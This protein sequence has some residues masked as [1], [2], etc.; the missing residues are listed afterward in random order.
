MA[1]RNFEVV[2]R[3]EFCKGCGL[4]VAFCKQGKLFIVKKPNKQGI[5]QA[6]V[7]PDVECSGCQQCVIICPDAAIEMYRL[8][9]A[10]DARADEPEKASGQ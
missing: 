9:T 5:Q 6:D 10:A 7:N 3:P 4:C 8:E 2:I 1:D